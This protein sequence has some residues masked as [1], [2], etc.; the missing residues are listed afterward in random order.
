MQEWQKWVSENK[1]TS[2]ENP[3]LS[4]AEQQKQNAIDEV[5]KILSR[6]KD[7]NS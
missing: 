5:E 6:K 2:K 7:D 3:K 1:Q 4:E